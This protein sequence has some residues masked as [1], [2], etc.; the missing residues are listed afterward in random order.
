MK[1]TSNN[2]FAVLFIVAIALSAT[3]INSLLYRN[4]TNDEGYY[5]SA[6]AV[7]TIEINS[8][9]TSIIALIGLTVFMVQCY[10]EN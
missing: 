1:Q 5:P 2:L 4:A 10:K 8:F 9:R 3:F 6:Q 7:Q